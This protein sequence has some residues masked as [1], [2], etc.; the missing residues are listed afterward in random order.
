MFLG[1]PDHSQLG[2]NICGHFT[3]STNG[4]KLLGVW[5]DS[6]LNFNQHIRNICT[7]ANQKIS[8]LYRIRNYLDVTQALTLSNAFVLSQFRYCSLVW[9]FCNKTVGHLIDKTQRRCLRVI[10]GYSDMS[11]GQMLETFGGDTVHVIHIRSLMLEVYK[12]T[13]GLNPVFMGEFFSHKRLSY[14]L[15]SSNLIT[16]PS[17][18]SLTYGTNSVHFRSCLLWNQLPDTIK[19]AESLSRCK[20]LLSNIKIICNCKLCK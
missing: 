10:Y 2:I 13:K 1:V 14:N 7:V 17:A 8:C 19:N 5:I 11:L 4:V 18:R 6:K 20:C 15:R 16:L 12:S 9:M 3:K